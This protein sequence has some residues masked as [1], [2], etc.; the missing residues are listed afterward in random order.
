VGLLLDHH[1]TAGSTPLPRPG[2][3]T[4]HQALRQL[5]NRLV[6]IL[7]ACLEDGTLYDEATAW[8]ATD[9]AAA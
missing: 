4:R 9:Q 1:L 2:G 3:K 5:A 6:R 7:Q 8:R